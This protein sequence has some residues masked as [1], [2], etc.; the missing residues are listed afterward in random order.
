MNKNTKLALVAVAI[1]AFAYYHMKKM[2]ALEAAAAKLVVNPPITGASITT[3]PILGGATPVLSSVD[4]VSSSFATSGGGTRWVVGGTANGQTYI[5]PEGNTGGGHYING[6]LN[7]PI[8]TIYTPHN[9][10]TGA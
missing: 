9:S 4:S 1:V 10:Q 5:F 2:K 6:L 8:G 3:P 7:V